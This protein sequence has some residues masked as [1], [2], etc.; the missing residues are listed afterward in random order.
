MKK[1]TDK[2]AL[3]SSLILLSSTAICQSFDL[4][5][6][7][8]D[9]TTVTIAVDDIQ[10]LDFANVGA[11]D[12]D[13]VEPIQNF[14]LMQNYPNPFNPTTT[15]EYQI[16]KTADVQVCVFNIKGQLIKEILHETQAEGVH[17]VTWNG[18]NQS[19]KDVSSGIYFYIVRSDDLTLTKKM[20]LLK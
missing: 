18:T 9:G 7:L 16:P 15:I 17:Q 13:I 14:Q 12:S 2:L 6:N 10:R 20:I 5:I 11:E 19:E 3:L 4:N 8:S 1:I